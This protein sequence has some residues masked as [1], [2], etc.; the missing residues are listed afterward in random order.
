MTTFYTK[1]DEV[2]LK[3]G[4]TLGFTAGKG[5]YAGGTPTPPKPPPSSTAKGASD[6]SSVAPTAT[7]P[8][9][10]KTPTTPLELAKKPVAPVRTLEADPSADERTERSGPPTPS[11]PAPPK[12]GQPESLY[13]RPSEVPLK[14]GQT[15]ALTAEGRYYAAGRP[16]PTK[17]ST[18]P[19]SS[20]VKVIAT[21]VK[22]S[23]TSPLLEHIVTGDGKK[24]ITLAHAA[25]PGDSRTSPKTVDK[26]SPLEHKT[27][28]P[29]S[30]RSS[31]P[32]V[33]A[34]QNHTTGVQTK[35]ASS[36]VHEQL[37]KTKIEAHVAK[38]GG[39]LHHLDKNSSRDVDANRIQIEVDPNTNKFAVVLGNN[40]PLRPTNGVAKIPVHIT[41]S[42]RH[43]HDSITIRVGKE[44]ATVTLTSKERAQV[45]ALRTGGVFVNGHHET[46][47]FTIK[48]PL[49]TVLAAKIAG[50]PLPLACALL[51]QESSGGVN[52]WGY[53]TAVYP[54]QPKPIFIGGGSYPDAPVTK[55]AYDAYQAERGPAKPSGSAA[56]EQGVGP[57]QLTTANVQNDAQDLGGAWRPLVNMIVGFAD[58]AAYIRDKEREGGTQFNGIA[59][60]NGIGERAIQYA[61]AERASK[62]YWAEV[63]GTGK[64]VQA[65]AG[66]YEY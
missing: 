38:S 22:A 16:N 15:V 32:H 53:D 34:A 37:A 61:T 42:Q 21:S 56:F 66:T 13:T 28:V 3:P 6:K 30:D 18:T 26:K 65:P 63:L 46:I 52:K 58:M 39:R 40:A 27:R 51:E 57:T 59:A 41:V 9:A 64:V 29:A 5:Y 4:Q 44:S 62:N 23:T 47:P 7:R 25:K 49:F 10:A 50:L 20:N 8:V 1:K 43:G 55:Q 2:S 12:V 14:P 17:A 19:T 54:G 60:Y 36:R 11:K 33:R 24:R 31:K 35:K 45:A 48:N